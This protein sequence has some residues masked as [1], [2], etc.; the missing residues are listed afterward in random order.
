M[1][2]VTFAT[3]QGSSA[4]GRGIAAMPATIIERQANSVRIILPSTPRFAM[5]IS[6]KYGEG[7]ADRVVRDLTADHCRP[8]AASFVQDTAAAVAAVVQVKEE[9]W[10][11]ATPAL[12]EPISTIALGVDGTCVLMVDD[13]HRQAMVASTTLDA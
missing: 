9:Q 12:P 5:Q 13:G 6:H 7:P 10:H 1:Y 2:G 3:L 11:H 8:V 4:N